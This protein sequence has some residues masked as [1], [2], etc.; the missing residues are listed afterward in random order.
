MAKVTVT[1]TP[2]P[3]TAQVAGFPLRVVEALQVGLPQQMTQFSSDSAAVLAGATPVRT[4]NAQATVQATFSA[5]PSLG[6]DAYLA[7][8]GYG[9]GGFYAEYLAHGTMGEVDFPADTFS[10][11][12]IEPGVIGARYYPAG[13]PVGKENHPAIT[14][15]RQMRDEFE[16]FAKAFLTGLGS[17]FR[18]VR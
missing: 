8:A 18:G 16:A 6:T 12:G 14:P 4:G 9:Y 7:G 13:Y 17:F 10:A 3:A 2:D 11:G 5:D 1:V 15:R